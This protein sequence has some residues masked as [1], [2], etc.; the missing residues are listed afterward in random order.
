MTALAMKL[1]QLRSKN[2]RK[3]ERWMIIFS[4]TILIA[5]IGIFNYFPILYS[6]IGSFFKWRPIKGIFKFVGFDNYIWMLEDPL[7][8]TS[9]TNTLVFALVSCLFYVSLGLIFATLIYSVPRFQSFFRTTYFL[10]VITSGV[11]VSL[12]WKYAFYNTNNGV[13]N[14]VLEFFGF[15]PQM[16]L[17]DE[18]QVLACIIVMTVWKEIGYAIVIFIAG[19]NEIPTELFEAATIDGASRFQSF[20]RIIIPLIKPTTLLVAVTGMINFLQVFNQV[21]LMTST[22]GKNPGGPGTSSYTM[23]LWIYE[24][25]FRDFEFG[26]ASAIGYALVLVIMVFTVIQFRLNRSEE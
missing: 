2:Q 1:G 11:A 26:R 9:I 21:M 5:Y 23:M 19:L 3:Q 25:G 12:L 13:F 10:P 18:N 20:R 17:L 6:F 16:W 4:M 15:D 24:K 7:F 22:A 14:V 8:W